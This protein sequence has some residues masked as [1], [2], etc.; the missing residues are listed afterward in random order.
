MTCVTWSSVFFWYFFND[1]LVLNICFQM[2]DVLWGWNN[3]VHVFDAVKSCWSEPQTHVS[4]LARVT[5]G[6]LCTQCVI[7]NNNVTFKHK[8]KFKVVLGWRDRERFSVCRAA[9]QPPGPLTPVQQSAA[10]DTFVEAES[11][12]ELLVLYTRSHVFISTK[13]QQQHRDIKS[14]LAPRSPPYLNAGNQDEWHSLPRLS[15]MDM[16]GNVRMWCN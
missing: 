11:W 8:G 10:E 7:L 14:A 13:S 1:L 4:P 5:F 15:N 16:V 12:W 3:E 9:L 2:E 6:L